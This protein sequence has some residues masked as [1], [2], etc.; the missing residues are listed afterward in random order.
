MASYT[1][2]LKKYL[3]ANGCWFHRQGNGD[4]EIWESPHSGRRFQVDSKIVSR[5]T[6][7][8]VCKQAGLEKAF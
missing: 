7:N 4:H 8:E 6:A 1:R 5:H 3:K 2:D